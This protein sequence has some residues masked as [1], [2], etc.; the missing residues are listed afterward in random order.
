[1]D[2]A[3]QQSTH[4]HRKKISGRTKLALGLIIGP[5]VLIALS[6]IL[7]FATNTPSGPLPTT[8]PDACTAPLTDGL[9]SVQNDCTTSLFGQTTASESFLNTVLLIITGVGI[10]SWLPGLIIGF[11]LLA[12]KPRATDTPT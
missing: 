8:V 11:V 5:T 1:M 4:T 7:F 12:K 2:Q 3:P 10:A 6:L 9:A